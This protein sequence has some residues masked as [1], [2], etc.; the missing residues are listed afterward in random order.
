MGVEERWVMGLYMLFLV[1]HAMVVVDL[2]LWGIILKEPY[3]SEMFIV[4][5][6]HLVSVWGIAFLT[7]DIQ[8][9]VIG[10]VIFT[11]MIIN[12]PQ[13]REISKLVEHISVVVVFSYIFRGLC[14]FFS[15][16]FLDWDWLVLL[17]LVSE[18]VVFLWRKGLVPKFLYTMN[19]VEK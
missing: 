9:I 10:S 4:L 7:K 13:K 15:A 14:S 18:C 5:T 12:Y 16:K 1:M 17:T 2:L 3:S 8:D 6:G 11:F 19:V